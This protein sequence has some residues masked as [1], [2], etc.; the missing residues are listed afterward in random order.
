MR[1]VCGMVMCGDLGAKIHTEPITRNHHQPHIEQYILIY[2]PQ[3]NRAL[4]PREWQYFVP[5]R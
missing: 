3:Q 5:L 1:I 2:N 4:H